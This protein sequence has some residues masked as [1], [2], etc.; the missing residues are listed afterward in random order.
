MSLKHEFNRLSHLFGDGVEKTEKQ[1]AQWLDQGNR[2]AAE[3]KHRMRHQIDTG[4]RGVLS[5]EESFVRHMRENPA[6]YIIGAALLIGAL[7]ARLV[8]DV[9]R[10]PQAPLL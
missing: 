1:A 10:P 2:Q 6:L 8:L 5:V 9:R 7:I 4:R 3:L